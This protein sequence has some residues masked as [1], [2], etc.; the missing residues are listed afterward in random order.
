MI[1]S[2]TIDRRTFVAG[3]GGL[4]AASQLPSFARADDFPAKDFSFVVPY[5][6][7]GM[8]DT[9]ARLL[10]DKFFQL[11]NKHVVNDYRVGAGGAIAANY[12][13]GVKPDGY[14]ALVATNS[15]FAVIPAVMKVEYDPKT[16]FTPL[17]ALDSAMVAAVHPSLPVKTMQEFIAYA[18]ANPN[19]V[20]YASAG[21]GGVGHMCGEWLARKAGIQLV[22]IPYNGAPQAMQATISN[23]TQLVFGP[24]AYEF[25]VSKKLTGLALLTNQKRWFKLPD[26]PTSAECGLAGWA[27]R[28]WHTFIV[29]S[30][31][32]DAVKTRMFEIVGKILQ[33][34]DIKEKI[35]TVG[36]MPADEDLATLRKR[37]DSDI[38]EYGVLIKETGLAAK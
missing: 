30:K 2:M 35:A 12:Y 11:T 16:D 24:E 14:T 31:T 9:L 27:P 33:M 25:I 37:A 32:P 19:K 38:A 7:G 13:R 8:S 28:S 4:L 34:P 15:F 3:A 29:L 36:L 22:H 1:M 10:G 20:A 6:P 23:E 17:M 26:L 18:K 5:A 21:K